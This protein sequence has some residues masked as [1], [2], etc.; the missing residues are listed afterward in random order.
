MSEAIL[1]RT[2]VVTRSQQVAGYELNLL[3]SHGE[4]AAA[5]GVAALL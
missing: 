1:H 4:A 3:S 2:P 5:G